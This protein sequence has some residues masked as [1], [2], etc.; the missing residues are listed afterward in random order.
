MRKTFVIG[1]IHGQYLHFTTLMDKLPIDFNTDRLVLLGDYIDR[2]PDSMAVVKYIMSLVNSHGSDTVFP[3]LGNHEDM[4]LRYLDLKKKNI[5]FKNTEAMY[6]FNGGKATMDSYNNKVPQDHIDFLSSLEFNYYDK[7]YIYVHAGLRPGVP[8]EKQ[9]K[10][11]MLWIREQFLNSH[12]NFG[13]KIIHGHTI[14]KTPMI[15]PHA[16]GIDTGCFRT[17]ILTAIELPKERI[18]Q[19]KI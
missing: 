14:F 18:F 10:D 7:N 16:I 12:Y 6:F 17:G 2:G 9:D 3:L 5:C 4:L 8:F 13:R 15:K 11:D 1:D 19:V